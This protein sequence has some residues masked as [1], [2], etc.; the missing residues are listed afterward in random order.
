MTAVQTALN[1]SVA[2]VALSFVCGACWIALALVYMASPVRSTRPSS[3]MVSSAAPG[4]QLAECNHAA[5]RLTHFRGMA[6]TAA[7]TLA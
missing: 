6:G 4:R 3:P 2:Y 1:I 7:K 5:R